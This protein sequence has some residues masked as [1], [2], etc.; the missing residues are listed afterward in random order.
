MADAATGAFSGFTPQLFQ[1]LQSLAFY[2]S[3]AW[4]DENRAVYEAAFK[5]PFEAYL[6]ALSQRCRPAG[7]PLLGNP[8]R[9]I[10]RLNRDV[11]FAKNKEP[12]KTNG[13]CVLTRNG[14]KDSPGLFYTHIA[15]EGC[16]FAAGFYHPEPEQLS[17]L[18]KAM[19][20]RPQRFLEVVEALGAHGL[21]LSADEALVRLPK[22]FEAAVPEIQVYLKLKNLVV[23]RHFEQD[24]LFDGSAMVDGAIKFADQAMPLL[25]FGW[26][27]L[28]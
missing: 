25:R 20:A 12:Y 19:S 10:F 3:K 5:Q 16:F 7:L 8:K 18:R 13:G 6:V 26:D 23:M 4:F 1:F 24:L 21:V 22:G 28:G 11:R 14:M 15:V 2:Q 27:V 17:A 9:G